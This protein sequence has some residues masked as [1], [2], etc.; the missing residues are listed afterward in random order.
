MPLTEL[1][2][3]LLVLA[4]RMSRPVRLPSPTGDT[5][6]DRPA[7]QALWHIVLDGPLRPTVL[8]GLLEIDLSVVSRQV[9]ALEDA[10]LVSRV[11]D[12]ADA[13]AALVSATPAGLAAFQETQR[14]RTQLLDEVLTQW[15]ATDR[16]AFTALLR[17]FNTELEASIARRAAEAAD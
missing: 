4:R 1:E 14:L 9:R 13:R 7:Y 2:Q 16:E 5:M 12:P 11:T 6:L 8:A 15:P 3:Q 17:R 10:E